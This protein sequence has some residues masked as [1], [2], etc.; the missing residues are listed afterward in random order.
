MHI[1]SALQVMQHRLPERGAGAELSREVRQHGAA[2]ASLPSQSSFAAA[3][4][5]F[6][7]TSFFS[8]CRC[9]S[10]LLVSDGKAELGVGQ[11]PQ[12]A[13]STSLQKSAA[14]SIFLLTTILTSF[15]PA[16]LLF[17]HSPA[18]RLPITK[19]FTTVLW[20]LGTIPLGT[21]LCLYPP[22]PCLFYVKLVI[23]G[24]RWVTWIWEVWNA[25]SCVQ[26]RCITA[27]SVMLPISNI[28]K[29]FTEY[30]SVMKNR[31]ELFWYMCP[32]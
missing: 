18:P 10:L 13:L 25:S 16:L 26:S 6:G 20:F 29:M 23:Q 11:G 22:L 2:A 12:T 9:C 7:F 17:L 21:P 32:V 5:P 15:T 19:T 24:S 27:H 14:S 8:C 1:A 4:P 3:R 30:Q 28:E 31:K